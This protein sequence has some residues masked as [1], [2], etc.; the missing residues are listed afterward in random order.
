LKKLYNLMDVGGGLL[1]QSCIRAL[2]NRVLKTNQATLRQTKEAEAS[3]HIMWSDVNAKK[4]R[5]SLF[6]HV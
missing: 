2:W 4:A 6:D 1:F 5:G 3:A